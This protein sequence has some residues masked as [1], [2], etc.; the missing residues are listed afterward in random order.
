M[1]KNVR[2]LLLGGMLAGGLAISF[3]SNRQF[4]NQA[5]KG[6]VD[7]IYRGR[8]TDAFFISIDGFGREFDVRPLAKAP[9]IEKIVTK[10]DSLF[11]KQYTDTVILFHQQQVFKYTLNR[12]IS[13]FGH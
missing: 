2:A 5:F 1:N 11:K 4:H 9:P 8:K 6:I 3:L 10:G 13:L 7:S 12:G